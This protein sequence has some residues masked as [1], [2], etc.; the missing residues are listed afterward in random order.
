MPSHEKS[1]V[2]EGG[3]QLPLMDRRASC[4]QRLRRRRP[5]GGQRSLRAIAAELEKA[6][7]VSRSGKPYGATAIARMLGELR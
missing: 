3:A 4:A 1:P 6:G 5:K 2:A 7:Y